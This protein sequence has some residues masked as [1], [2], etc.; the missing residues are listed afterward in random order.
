M[1]TRRFGII[2]VAVVAIGVSLGIVL[3]Q[4]EPVSRDASPGSTTAR[5]MLQDDFGGFSEASPSLEALVDA[6][7]LVAAV[8]FVKQEAD[9]WPETDPQI[10][11]YSRFV[12]ELTEVIRG[13]AKSGDRLEVFMPGGAQAEW[14]NPQIGGTFKPRP[15]ERVVQTS[16]P[17]F[18]S[19]SPDREE[20]V[21][22][23]KT[24]LQDGTPVW[25]AVP[26]G[27]YTIANGRVVSIFGDVPSDPSQIVQRDAKV[28]VVGKT[29]AELRNAVAAVRP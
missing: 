21:F 27:R 3:G 20:I 5:P 10:W 8:R 16:E 19:F 6:T 14:G 13:E 4:G 12:V 25:W 7:D 2:W 17:G 28:D 9:F 22:L 26:E 11:V 1:L 24:E 15:G 18:P 23:M 29:P